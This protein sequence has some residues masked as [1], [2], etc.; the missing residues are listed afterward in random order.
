MARNGHYILYIGRL[1]QCS[2]AA[3]LPHHTQVYGMFFS[4]TDLTF[5]AAFN[6]LLSPLSGTSS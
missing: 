2:I 3:M 6:R 1:T 5:I 4:G